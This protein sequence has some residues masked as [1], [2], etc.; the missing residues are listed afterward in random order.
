MMSQEVEMP[1]HNIR[2]QIPHDADDDSGDDDLEEEDQDDV[3]DRDQVT[4]HLCPIPILYTLSPIPYTLYPIPYTLYLLPYA[5][6]PTLNPKPPTR[7]ATSVPG[8]EVLVAHA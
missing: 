8:Q 3:P 7:V 5:L 4:L 1:V 6:C 2:I